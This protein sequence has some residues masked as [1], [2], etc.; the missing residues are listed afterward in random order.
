MKK[1]FLLITINLLFLFILNVDASS[2]QGTITGTYVSLRT[3]PGT[4]YSK[5]S[6][7][8]YKNQT[9]NMP[10]NQLYKT[11]SGCNSGYWYKIYYVGTN[12]GYVCSSYLSI[13]N[14][15]VLDIYDRPWTTPKK[16]IFGGAKFISESY[17][18]KG[19]FNSYLKKFNVNPAT[20]RIYSHQY[21]ANL[22]APMSEAAISYNGYL[23]GNLLSL[24]LEF[25]IPIFNN[26]P[27]YTVLPGSNPNL[28]CKSEVSDY[29]FEKKLDEQG[30]PETYKCK[31]RMLHDIHPNWIFKSLNTG[32]DFSKSVIAEKGVCSIQGSTSYFEKM[33]ETE[34]KSYNSKYKLVNGYCNTEGSWY[35]ANYDTV[36]YYL[37][38]RN[39]MTEKYILMFENL[40]YSENY[41]SSIVQTILNGTFM[42]E[43]SLLDNQL[44]SNIFVEAGR[45]NNIS[46]VYLASLAR[47]ESGVNGSLATSGEEFTYEGITYKGLYNF[48]NIGANSG[49]SSPILA[50]L[51]YASGGDDSV[52]VS[53]GT[54]I[55]ES[56]ILYKI[57][58]TKISNIIT[59]IKVGTT[60]DLLNKALSGY[61]VTYSSRGLVKTGMSITIS[62]GNNVVTYIIAVKGDV[63][64]SGEI[65]ATDYV[66]IKN[67]IMER[68]GSSLTNAELIAADV[69]NDGVI[70]A[71]DYVRIKNIIMGR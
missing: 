36:A 22:K 15:K 2:Y 39:F 20:N 62:D 48:F 25:V 28:S 27:S 70:A 13:N 5:I 32:L 10:D 9:Y 1:K 64:G 18:N 30:F 12:V 43:Y 66:K 31:L 58:G 51:V 47:Q 6:Y 4:N 8:L 52:K 55:N 57:G 26:M 38:P 63:D 23:K 69:D 59:N 41:T 49:A 40:G 29:A 17:I 68:P 67:K 35:I 37:D 7:T 16:A 42:Q 56:D 46:S 11:E 60:T 61:T 3:G 71:T 50:G 24:S 21:M 53:N 19:Q 33:T 14:G 45:L 65:E 44:Y 54:K 34:C